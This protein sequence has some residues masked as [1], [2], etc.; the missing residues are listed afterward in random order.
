MKRAGHVPAC[1]KMNA[2]E[3]E[4]EAGQLPSRAL[5]QKYSNAPE[6]LRDLGV[7][8]AGQQGGAKKCEKMGR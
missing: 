5:R 1:G 6:G 8:S 4:Q 7:R 2:G 3:H